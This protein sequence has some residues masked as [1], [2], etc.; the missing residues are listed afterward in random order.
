M[1]AVSLKNEGQRIYGAAVEQ[2]KP[3]NVALDFAIREYIEVR[4]LLGDTSLM[5][6]AK[7]YLRYGKTITKK[8]PLDEILDA[9]LKVL[10]SDGRSEYHIRDVSRHIGT[11]IRRNRGDIKGITSTQIDTWLRSLKVG[12]RTRNNYRDSILNFFHFA[13]AEGSS[14]PQSRLIYHAYVN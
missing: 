10:K 5:E 4:K 8:A 3:L 7:S 12:G 6:A 2:L 11:F 13:R 14:A 1:A 9:M